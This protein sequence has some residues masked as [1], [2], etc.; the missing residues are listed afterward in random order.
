[1]DSYRLH[2]NYSDKEGSEELASNSITSQEGDGLDSHFSGKSPGC[3][4]G[5]YSNSTNKQVIK[6]PKNI[7]LKFWHENSRTK[8]EN[9]P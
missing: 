2:A 6:F 9:T 3:D 5:F 8:Y 4:L 1:M 7:K